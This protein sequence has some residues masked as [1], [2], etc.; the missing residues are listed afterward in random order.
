M[1]RDQFLALPPRIRRKIYEF[2]F[3]PELHIE[4]LP[5]K[6]FPSP[7]C[8]LLKVSTSYR[9]DVLRTYSNRTIWIFKSPAAFVA[10]IPSLD[11]D[12]LLPRIET[13]QL[14]LLAPLGDGSQL[15]HAERGGSSHGP[16]IEPLYK[17][18]RNTITG[19]P[20]DMS[21]RCVRFDLTHEWSWQSLSIARLVHI[22]SPA[23]HRKSKGKV[24]FEIVG[25]KT[26]EGRVFVEQSTVGLAE[27][28]G[29]MAKRRGVVI[30]AE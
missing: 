12:G 21:V 27:V 17:A 2:A 18:W 25:C 7:D 26:E 23:L 28:S 24:K 30:G 15:T 3:G 5:S 20:M 22:L 10:F 11:D 9:N 4:L 16:N 8:P 1:E 14:V 19:L 13:I 6:Q 29:N